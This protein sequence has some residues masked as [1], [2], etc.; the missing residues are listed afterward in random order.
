MS[1]VFF[2]S[3]LNTGQKTGLS[4]VLSFGLSLYDKCFIIEMI[5]RALRER[6]GYQEFVELSRICMYE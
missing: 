6:Q 1:V 3:F 5:V 2:S 4:L